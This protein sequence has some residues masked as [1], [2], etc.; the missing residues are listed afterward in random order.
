M[1]VVTGNAPRSGTSAMMRALV[2]LY[3]PHSYAE[4]FPEYVAKEQNPEGYWDVKK[5]HL[6]TDAPI[7]TEENTVIK[8]WAPMFHRINVDDVKLLVFM[9][10]ADFMRQVNSIERTSSA[11]GFTVDSKQIAD[12][13]INQRTRAQD[14]FKNTNTLVVDMESF[15]ADPELFIDHIREVVPCQ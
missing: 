12:M 6:W 8:L 10:R 1:I 11:E 9:D 15:R 5:E 3:K 2:E 14:I 4:L 7:P 13:F